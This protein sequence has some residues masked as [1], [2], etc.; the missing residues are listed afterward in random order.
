MTTAAFYSQLEQCKTILKKIDLLH[1]YQKAINLIK[2][3]SASLK[4]KPYKDIWEHIYKNYYST[5]VLADRSLILFS[6]KEDPKESSFSY[7]ENPYF[8]V[9][10]A[11]F[12]K[13]FETDDDSLY[14]QYLMERAKEH[15]TPIRYDFY[16]KDYNPGLH[17]ASHMHIG[18]NSE[19][20][21]GCACILTPLL[22]IFFIV[23]QCYP[24]KWTELRENSF[25]GVAIKNYVQKI[26]PCFFSE[27][28]TLE[29]YLHFLSANEFE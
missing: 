6:I 17:P 20:R 16:P 23:R 21:I 12:E 19:I 13:E 11:E 28:D 10:K 22:F 24:E 2:K 8:Y 29:C 7:L 9:S 26:D 4:G 27:N 25:F 15:V 14:E 3:P 18:H 5:F 1:N